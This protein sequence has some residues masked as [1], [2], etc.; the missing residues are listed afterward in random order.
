[1]YCKLGCVCEQVDQKD[2]R[3]TI[4]EVLVEVNINKFGTWYRTCDI[5]IL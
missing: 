4:K 3:M 2:F 5:F 1:M